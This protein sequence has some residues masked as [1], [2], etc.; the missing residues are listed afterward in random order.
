MSLP[1]LTSQLSATL[2]T[3]ESLGLSGWSSNCSGCLWFLVPRIERS[4]VY[5]KTLH[6][7]LHWK[8]ILLRTSSDPYDR[9]VD[10]NYSVLFSPDHVN[11][12]STQHSPHEKQII[13]MKFSADHLR[14][15]TLWCQ[16]QRSWE[17]W[18]ESAYK[19]TCLSKLGKR[20]CALLNL[21]TLPNMSTKANWIAVGPQPNI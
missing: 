6:S 3:A 5:W 18:E 14:K 9:W 17:A 12:F 1:I 7:R 8:G 11:L 16:G 13:L 10:S 20:I 15:E 19:W 4:L 21:V 2:T